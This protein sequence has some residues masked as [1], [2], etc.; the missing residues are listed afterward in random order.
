MDDIKVLNELLD[1]IWGSKIT[2]KKTKLQ[3]DK[4]GRF[5]KRRK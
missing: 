5:I 1:I 3:R 2:N 4:K